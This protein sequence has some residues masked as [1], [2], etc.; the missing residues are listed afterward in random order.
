MSHGMAGLGVKFSIEIHPTTTLKQFSW[1]VRWPAET[2]SGTHVVSAGYSS[3]YFTAKEA[4]EAAE[5]Y[6]RHV[7]EVAKQSTIYDFEV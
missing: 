5:D 1:T 2:G 4:R 3:V 6:A 7:S